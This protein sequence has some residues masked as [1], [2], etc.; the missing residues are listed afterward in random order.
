MEARR[1]EMASDVAFLRGEECQWL[2]ISRRYSRKRISDLAGTVGSK[3]G[4]TL[5]LSVGVRKIRAEFILG[6]VG[7]IRKPR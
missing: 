2:T 6:R 5:S 7:P 4:I 3:V 1:R